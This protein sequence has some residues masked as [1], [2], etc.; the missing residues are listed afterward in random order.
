MNQ[1]GMSGTYALCERRPVA[2]YQIYLLGC[3]GRITGSRVVRADNDVD[4]RVLAK[5]G[6][7]PE[8]SAEIWNGT[9]LVGL[10]FSAHN[11]ELGGQC[12]DPG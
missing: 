6:L 11:F 1:N 9:R 3:D 8:T 2:T 12:K 4:A 5:T 7:L 10:V